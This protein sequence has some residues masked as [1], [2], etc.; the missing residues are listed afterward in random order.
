MAKIYSLD[1]RKQLHKDANQALDENLAPNEPVKIIIRGSYNSSIIGTDRR[2]FVFKKGFM[3][4]ATFG[5]K[6]TSWNYQNITGIQ[7]ETGMLGGFVAIMAPGVES[8]DMNSWGRGKK[9]P[10]K[11]PNAIHINE[12]EQARKGVA[13]MRQLISESQM[14]GSPANVSTSQDIP[15]KIKQLAELHEQGIL[16]AEEFQAKKSELLARI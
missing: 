6:F 8:A 7:I 4:G 16:T 3:G 9:D 10:S 11:S 1:D 12:F 15:G 2:A 14:Q 5:K 13:L